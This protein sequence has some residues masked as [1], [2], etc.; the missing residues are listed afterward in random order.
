[1]IKYFLSIEGI[2]ELWE[3]LFSEGNDIM[4]LTPE[5]FT[6]EGGFL[7][8]VYNLQYGQKALKN[9][10]LMDDVSLPQWAQTPSDF[11]RINR[12]SFNLNNMLFL[13]LH[14]SHAK[15]TILS[16][17]PLIPISLP[18]FPDTCIY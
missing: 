18:S 12:N 15:T 10:K 3:Y 13:S 16:F 11:I 4:E 8:N 9:I 1:M 5:F 17:F 2:K 14:S 6:G 7:V